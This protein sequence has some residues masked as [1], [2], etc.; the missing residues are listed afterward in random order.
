MSTCD[1]AFNASHKGKSKSFFQ[2]GYT[3]KLKSYGTPRDKDGYQPKN[4]GKCSYCRKLGHYVNECKKRLKKKKHKDS[5]MVALL[6]RQ[7][8]THK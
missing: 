8:L 1:Q 2:S 5:S 6:M 3:L 7:H 4:N